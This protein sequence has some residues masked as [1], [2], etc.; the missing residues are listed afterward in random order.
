MIQKQN[1]SPKREPLSRIWFLSRG[2]K[3]IDPPLTG[4]RLFYI[5][6]RGTEISI[7]DAFGR[8]HC[9]ITRPNEKGS[10]NNR[11]SRLY[12]YLHFKLN[13]RTKVVPVSLLVMAAYNNQ[14][15]DRSKGEVIDH[16]D[17][18][19]LNNNP[20]NLRIVTRA[21]NDRDAGFMRKLRN[22]KIYVEMFPHNIILDGYERMAQ[23]KTAHTEWQ[24]RRLDRQ[25]LLQ[26]FIGPNFQ[27]VNGADRMEYEIELKNHCKTYAKDII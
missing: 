4:W 8:S 3:R 23:W 14:V 2:Y 22:N 5:R 7:L 18:N 9:V 12:Y 17:G 15:P 16:I 10:I 13:G 6:I 20:G 11:H 27:I 1:S 26:I 19:T 21:I 25:P 24:Y